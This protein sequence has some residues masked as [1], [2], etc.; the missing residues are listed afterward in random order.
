MIIKY[1]AHTLS[2]KPSADWQSLEQQ[3][4]ETAEKASL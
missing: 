1:F 4:N 3:L 2:G